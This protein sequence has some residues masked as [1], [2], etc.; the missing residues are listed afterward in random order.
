MNEPESF[1]LTAHSG[2]WDGFSSVIDIT[3]SAEEYV[4][5]PSGSQA[6]FV[7]LRMDC[8]MVGRD[9]LDGLKQAAMEM[10]PESAKTREATTE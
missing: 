3:G 10:R 6:D 9:F 7:A 2:F 5:S 1:F 8:E 4:T